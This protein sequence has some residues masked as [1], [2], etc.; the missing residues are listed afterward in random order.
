MLKYD[1][2]RTG[3]FEGRMKIS[4]SFTAQRELV[5][6]LMGGVVTARRDHRGEDWFFDF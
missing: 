1:P 5:E 3:V 6:G 2:S 4:T